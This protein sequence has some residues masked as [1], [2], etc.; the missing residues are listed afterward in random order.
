LMG[1]DELL[2]SGVLRAA[3]LM[4]VAA[5]TAPKAKGVDNVK[6]AVVS[7]RDE[8]ERLAR[9]MEELAPTYGAFFARDARNVRDSEAVLLVGADVVDL[10][11][12]S[13]K[14]GGVDLNTY[15]ALVNLGIAVGS[16]VKTA[17]YLNIDNRVMYSV[18]VAAKELGLLKAEYVLGIP[19]TAKAKNPYFDRYW[20]RR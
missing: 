7:D 9:K 17:S 14:G 16:A 19:L 1:E 5:K 20:W 12:P 13:P 6:V 10:G 2:K 18:G 8:L 3:E 11:I 4:A 15:M